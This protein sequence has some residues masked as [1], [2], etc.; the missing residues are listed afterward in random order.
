MGGGS[1]G[2]DQDTPPDGTR[3]QREIEREPESRS[4]F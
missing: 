1:G 3:R 4:G 2:G